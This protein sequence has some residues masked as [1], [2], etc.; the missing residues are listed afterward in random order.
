MHANAAGLLEDICTCH[1]LLEIKI[2]LHLV[3]KSDFF[4]RM[5]TFWSSLSDFDHAINN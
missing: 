1:V 3:T 4:V 2:L 5:L